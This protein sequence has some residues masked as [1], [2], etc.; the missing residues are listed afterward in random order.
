MAGIITLRLSCRAILSPKRHEYWK[1]KGR[2]SQSSE[3]EVEASDSGQHADMADPLTQT[4]GPD[5]PWEQPGSDTEGGLG[6]AV[7]EGIYGLYFVQFCL[8]TSNRAMLLFREASPRIL[9]SAALV[10]NRPPERGHRNQGG[11]RLLSPTT[12]PASP[13]TLL[14]SSWTQSGF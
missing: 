13:H 2:S 3:H 8:S 6:S 9:G 1:G 4:Q 10:P 12:P 7:L 5:R 14:A 11:A